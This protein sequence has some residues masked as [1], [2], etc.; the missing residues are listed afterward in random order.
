MPSTSQL[1][2]RIR[3][4][5]AAIVAVASLGGCQR[6]QSEQ[7]TTAETSAF[8]A[9]I[10]KLRSKY[11][12]AVAAGDPSAL[13]PLLADGAVMVR[14]GGPDWD[15]MAA[16]APGAP[17]PPGARIAIRPIEVVALSKEWAYE[18]GTATTTY[19]PQGANEARQLQDTYLLLFR[20]TGNGWKA[21][22][23]VASSAPPPS[24]WPQD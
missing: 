10:D 5:L 1:V 22:R 7:Q 23:E 3:P 8:R 20:N 11:E 14:P 19:T 18:F 17:F 9:E 24:G 2:R 12:T 6:D 4:A 15:A 21:Y 13:T 16:A